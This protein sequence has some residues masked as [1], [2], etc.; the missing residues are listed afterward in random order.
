MISGEGII[1]LANVWVFKVRPLIIAI[2]THKHSTDMSYVL[3]TFHRARRLLNE[4]GARGVKIL[5]SEAQGCAM[6][7]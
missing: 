1:R 2:V 5:S 7:A 6:C 4:T 3:L